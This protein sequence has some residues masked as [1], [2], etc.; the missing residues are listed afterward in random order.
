MPTLDQLLS[1]NQAWQLLS[2]N[3]AWAAKVKQHDPSFF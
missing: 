2:N 3:Q 1:N